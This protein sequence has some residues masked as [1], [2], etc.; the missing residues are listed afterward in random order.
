MNNKKPIASSVPPRS[1]VPP[2][3]NQMED[4]KDMPP[5]GSQMNVV[6]DEPPQVKTVI[7]T[8]LLNRLEKSPV[9]LP[10]SH[11]FVITPKIC[12]QLRYFIKKARWDACKKTFELFIHETPLMSAFRWIADIN[13]R[14]AKHLKSPFCDLEQ[15][16]L[17]VLMRDSK[18]RDIAEFKAKK[19]KILE[20]SCDF[21]VESGPLTH[22]VLIEYDS[23][24][25][26]RLLAV[27]QNASSLSLRTIDEEWCQSHFETLPLP[28][29]PKDP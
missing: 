12:S 7:P 4:V 25:F 15:D 13:D 3:W 6:H 22:R 27:D 14:H 9:G 20:H 28:S 17:T 18:Q 1:A 5:W 8:D 29:E 21:G 10:D 11:E 26:P 24:E 23:L 2:E 16:S 19:L